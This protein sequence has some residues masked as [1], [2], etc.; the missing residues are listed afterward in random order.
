MGG[1]MRIDIKQEEMAGIAGQLV[2]D[3]KFG[4]GLL[5]HLDKGGKFEVRQAELAVGL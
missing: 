1:E 5:G 2:P 4:G 3:V